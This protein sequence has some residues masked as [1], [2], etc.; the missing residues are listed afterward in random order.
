MVRTVDA[1]IR[2]YASLEVETIQAQALA[3]RAAA[4]VS[5]KAEI[6]EELSAASAALAE[7]ST[8][9]V[10]GE[11]IGDAAAATSA[12]LS[13]WALASGAS[14][15]EIETSIADSTAAFRRLEIRAGLEGTLEAIVALLD[16]LE[17][18]DILL[19]VSRLSIDAQREATLAVR[20]EVTGWLHPAVTP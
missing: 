7:R 4:L 14:V 6:E 13:R 12:L 20:A 17:R 5:K 16:S 2:R 18:S 10:R 15:H 1:G 19:T 11:S 9:L 3:A 8:G